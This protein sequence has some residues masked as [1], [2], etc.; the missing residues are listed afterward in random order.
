[1]FGLSFW[2]LAMILIVAL[3]VLGPKRLPD[4]ARTI[5]GGLRSLRR[6]SADL[7][8]AIE[9]P[10]REVQEP[11]EEMR[12]EI[13]QTVHHFEGEIAKSLEETKE[14]IEESVAGYDEAA[15]LPEG[16]DDEREAL[17]SLAE[18]EPLA[19]RG[20]DDDLSEEPASRADRLH[21]DADDPYANADD[22]YANAEDDDDEGRA[23]PLPEVDE[24]GR[25]ASSDPFA[26]DSSGAALLAAGPQPEIDD[27]PSAGDD[28]ASASANAVDTVPPE[29]KDGSSSAA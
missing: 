22:L 15:T 9:E 20:L 25:V 5:G 14:G 28:D 21:A 16:D 27:E 3:V 8:H 29:K 2:E 11:L 4:L 18:A 1:M 23:G 6:A 10:L 26:L 7:R 17:P 13:Y 24:R 12:R 19:E